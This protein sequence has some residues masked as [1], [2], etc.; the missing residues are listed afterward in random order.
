MGF[1]HRES[2][3]FISCVG[4][5]KPRRAKAKDLYQSDWFKKARRYVEQNEMSW[6]ILSAEYGL[7]HPD[8]LIDP[9]EKT[10]NKMNLNKRKQW[11]QMI[12]D[13][14]VE[15]IPPSKIVFFAGWKYREFLSEILR[16][17][18]YLIEIP[19]ENMPI[20]KQ[21]SWFKSQIIKERKGL[22]L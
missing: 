13:E 12:S 20:G 7:V 10:L 4:K 3:A 1:D 15:N 2:I 8:D 9:Y 19:L 18:G 11:A 6:Y 14:I 17:N 21:L 5:K 16:E 22:L